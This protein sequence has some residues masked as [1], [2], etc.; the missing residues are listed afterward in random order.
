[1]VLVDNERLHGYYFSMTMNKRFWAKVV[2]TEQ[3]WLWT[4]AKRNK[5]YGA[6]V[7]V[8]DGLIVQ[9]RAHRYSWEM[10]VGPIPAGQCVLHACDTP[11]CVRPTHLFLGS[12]ADN[13]R[14]MCNKGRHR[15]GGT[16][17]PPSEC[18]YERGE[19]HHASKLTASIVRKMRGEHNAGVSFSRLARRYGVSL[20]TAFNA[21]K[22]RTWKHVE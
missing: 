9:G 2:K 20:V 5:G 6:F 19:R 17:T 16:K 22:R 12:K 15:P 21:V 11:A 7:Y 13:N 4:G 14:D 3:C 8:R 18:K 1:M 10:H